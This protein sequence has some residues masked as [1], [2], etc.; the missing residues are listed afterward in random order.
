[1]STTTRHLF[2]LLLLQ[3]HGADCPDCNFAL[4]PQ[5]KSTHTSQRGVVP[6]ALH[7]RQQLLA[8]INLPPAPDQFAPITNSFSGSSTSCAGQ[9]RRATLGGTDLLSLLMSLTC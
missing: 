7:Y 4:V 1:M 8:Q 2:L 5:P 9:G 6:L 3:L